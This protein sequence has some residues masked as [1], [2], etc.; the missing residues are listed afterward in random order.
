MTIQERIEAYIGFSPANAL[1]IEAAAIDAGLISG[2]TYVIADALAVKRAAVEVMKILLSTA[3]TTN[4]N[5]YGIKWDRASL[6][7]RIA[8][9]EE[10][11]EPTVPANRIIGL[12]PW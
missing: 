8:D 6:L 12:N 4:E 1:A 11:I 2:G 10:E 3:D 5:G 9:L 7:K